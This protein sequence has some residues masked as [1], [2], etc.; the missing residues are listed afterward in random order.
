[1]DGVALVRRGDVGQA[2]V[3][4]D[5]AEVVDDG[6]PG[7]AV[8]Q[9]VGDVPGLFARAHDPMLQRAGKHRRFELHGWCVVRGTLR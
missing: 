5:L 9:R 7:P 6:M 4:G 3:V 2:V 1:M 8:G